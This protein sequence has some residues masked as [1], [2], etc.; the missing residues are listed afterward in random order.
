LVVSA[1]TRDVGCGD[2]GAETTSKTNRRNTELPAYENGRRD[3]RGR[4]FVLKKEKRSE[5]RA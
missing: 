5:K 4:L 2:A 3:M 1:G